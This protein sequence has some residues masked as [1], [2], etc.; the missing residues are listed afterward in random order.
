M[1]EPRKIVIGD[2]HGALR[3]LGPLIEQ[4]GV[5]TDDTL[6]FLG[7][8]VDGWSNA[9]QVIDYLLVLEKKMSCVFIKG[10]H[11]A[12]CQQWLM[13]NMPDSEWLLHGGRETIASYAGYSDQLKDVHLDFFNRLRNYYVDEK[14]RLYIHAG[15]A[16]M[17]GPHKEHY[18]SN[19][20]WDRTL[21]EMALATDER[22]S[23]QSKRYPK[24]LLLYKEIFIGHTPTTNYDV[25][26]PM[27]ACNVWNADT[28][29][30]FKGKLS[31]LDADSKRF[32]QSASVKDYY[33]G[34][35]GRNK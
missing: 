31:A 3:A 22:I 2:I 17:H 34:E 16:S 8:F 13:G 6:I 32:W 27:K 28:G 15:F 18:A 23:Q 1:E 35:K 29:A 25:A 9:A 33:P 20:S 24:R 10:N 11:D 14:N 4:I 21:W 30:G 7:D 5:R 12:W 19:Y 26:T